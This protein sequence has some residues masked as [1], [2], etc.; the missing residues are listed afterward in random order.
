[1]HG[2][3]RYYDYSQDSLDKSNT[4]EAGV[5][6]DYRIVNWLTLSSNFSFY[7][8]KATNEPGR[9]NILRFEPGALDFHLTRSW[10]VWAGGGAQVA[11]YEGKARTMESVSAGI[12]Y[13]ARD[14][15]FSVTYQRGF[16]SAVGLSR[17]LSSDIIS[18]LFGYR[19]TSWMRSNLQSHYYRSRELDGEGLLNTLSAGGGLE[20][21]LS[22]NIVANVNG[23]YQNQHTRNFSIQGLG[24]NRITGYVGLQYFWPSRSER[25][26]N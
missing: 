8:N 18:A 17:L 11:E 12:E 25:G 13:T 16:T 6:F 4:Y 26:L 21:V 19:I 23:F 7:K 9:A 20:F 22:R 5:E 10:R 1:L 14:T 15:T 24:L 2:A 3:H